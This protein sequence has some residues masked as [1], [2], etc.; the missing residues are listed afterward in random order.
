M[1]T[2]KIEINK[3]AIGREVYILN[4]PLI[5]EGVITNVI[6]EETFEVESLEEKKYSISIF[7]IRYKEYEV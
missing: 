7:D 4:N 3:K 1:N 6:N 2:Q 5:S